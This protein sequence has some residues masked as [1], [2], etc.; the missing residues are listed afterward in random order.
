ME[1]KAGLWWGRMENMLLNSGLE[2]TSEN[3][4]DSQGNKQTNKKWILEQTNPE[5]SEAQKSGLN[6]HDCDNYVKT[7]SITLRKTD[8]KKMTSN[9]LNGLN[10]SEC[11]VRKPEGL[12]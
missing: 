4:I 7:T 10:Y 11:T 8:G 1:M 2:K 5:F 12:A 9:K 3:I 6:Y